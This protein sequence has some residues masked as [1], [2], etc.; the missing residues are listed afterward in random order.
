MHPMRAQEPWPLLTTVIAGEA[1]RPPQAG[2]ATAVC[3][4]NHQALLLILAAN[5]CRTQLLEGFDILQVMWAAC[6]F[7]HLNH[8]IDSR[9]PH[10]DVA[11]RYNL[12]PLP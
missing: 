9:N 3:L 5:S 8:I 10:G 1:W 7:F 12:G 11:Q 4:T 6:P 2:V